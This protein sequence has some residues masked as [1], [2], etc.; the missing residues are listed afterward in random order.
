MIKSIIE[1]IPYGRENSISR[2]F[3]T[4]VCVDTGLIESTHIDKDRE[5]RNL[6]KEARRDNVVLY[7]EDGG[8]FRPTEKETVDLAHYIATEEK[9]AKSTFESIKTAK[10]LLEDLR[11]GRLS[12]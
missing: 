2:K 10:A 6:L 9:R 8:Y 1:L 3:L 5:M 7:A 12:E 4:A 11:H